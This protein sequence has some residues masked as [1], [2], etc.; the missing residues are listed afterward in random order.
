LRSVCDEFGIKYYG[1]LQ[2]CLYDGLKVESIRKDECVF[3]HQFDKRLKQG[4]ESFYVH[5]KED[6]F[7]ENCTIDF[8]DVLPLDEYIFYDQ[9]HLF[10]RGNSLIADKVYQILVRQS[11]FQ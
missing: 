2:P 1:I 7:V 4:M 6:D 8:R 9:C 5:A 3:H 10:E 11:G